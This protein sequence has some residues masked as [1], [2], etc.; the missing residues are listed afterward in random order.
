MFEGSTLEPLPSA[1]DLD[2][3]STESAAKEATIPEA[4][5]PGEAQQTHEVKLEFDLGEVIRAAVKD[6]IQKLLKDLQVEPPAD[7][8]SALE[9]R[10]ATLEADLEGKGLL[11]RAVTVDTPSEEAGG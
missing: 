11:T 4:A 3:I 5:Q 2:A 7:A 6:E 8:F 10:V 1:A 9:K